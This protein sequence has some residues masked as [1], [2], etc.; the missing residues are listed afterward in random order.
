M[1]AVLYYYGSKLIDIFLNTQQEE[2]KD[3]DDHQ[4]ETTYLSSEIVELIL[5]KLPIL[6]YPK[7]RTTCSTWKTAVDNII[8]H[9]NHFSP[10]LPQSPYILFSNNTTNQFLS[11]SQ[12]RV[13]HTMRG[14]VCVASFEGWLVLLNPSSDQ[15]F[16]LNPIS[17]HKIMLPPPTTIELPNKS[18]PSSSNYFLKQ[19]VASSA[20]DSSDCF[21]AALVHDDDVQGTEIVSCRIKDKSWTLMKNEYATFIWSIAIRGNKLY[22]VCDFGHPE[23]VVDVYDL[24]D[25]NAARRTL[26]FLLGH[27]P[28]PCIKVNCNV[29]ITKYDHQDVFLVIGP[30][31]G[32]VFRVL[33][34]VDH[35]LWRK[36]NNEKPFPCSRAK[37]FQVFKRIERIWL[38]VDHLDDRFISRT[39]GCLV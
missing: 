13:D 9:N 11:L 3:H 6:D 35:C 37:G 26:C 38:P 23:Y 12:Q 10:P 22:A 29:F 32:D 18:S 34:L 4:A 20:P 19:V 30:S 21:V 36:R 24:H 1:V 31:E 25:A 8:A 15:I 14:C 28:P 16:F 17:N 33:P 39:L 7:L 27:R 5:Q 2:E